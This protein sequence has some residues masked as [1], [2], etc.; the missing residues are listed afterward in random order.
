[1][2]IQYPDGKSVE[3]FLLSRNENSMRVALENGDD[4][5]EYIEVQGK[6]VSE[7]LEPVE[8]TFEWQRRGKRIETMDESDFICS[9]QL[10][11]HLVRLLD[12]DSEKDEPARPRY[13][14]AGQKII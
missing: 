9:K 14:T 13:M 5:V 8:I 10:A 12:R 11:T 6:W 2:I 4:V 3:G 1:M 7:D